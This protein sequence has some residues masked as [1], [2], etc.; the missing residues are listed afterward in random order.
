MATVAYNGSSKV[1]VDAMVSALHFSTTPGFLDVGPMFAPRSGDHI[2][3][4]NIEFKAAPGGVG[5]R[6]PHLVPFLRRSFT[7]PEMF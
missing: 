3:G 6:T 2:G 7:M 5:T 4:I 1:S